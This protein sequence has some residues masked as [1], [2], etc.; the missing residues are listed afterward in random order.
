MCSSVLT[1]AWPGVWTGAGCNS[2]LPFL[3]DMGGL[4]PYRWKTVENKNVETIQAHEF[5]HPQCST[6]GAWYQRVK[7]FLEKTGSPCC[8]IAINSARWQTDG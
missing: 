3:P 2:V 5:L 7:S 4:D 8:N 6:S 1:V